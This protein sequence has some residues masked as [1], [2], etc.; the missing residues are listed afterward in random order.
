MII[1][2]P[3]LD[4]EAD[5]LNAASQTAFGVTEIPGNYRQQH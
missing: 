1:S 3:D 5:A 4:V 2:H